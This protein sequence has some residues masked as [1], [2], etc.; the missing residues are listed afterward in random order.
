[1]SVTFANREVCDLT[2]CD[3]A[4]QRPVH[5]LDYA[6]ATTQEITGEQVFAY[7]GQGHPKRVTFYGEKGGTLAVETQLLTSELFSICTGAEI[8]NTAKFIK[9]LVLEATAGSITVPPEVNLIP[10][11][12]NVYAEAD[13]LGTPVEATLDDHTI[14][15]TGEETGNYIVYGIEELTS[16]V[17]KM[18]IKSTTFPKAVTIYGETLMKGEDG[19]NYPYKLVVYKASPQQTLSFGFSNNGD[20]ATMTI[21]F[22]L[23]SD[24]NDNIMDMILI[25]DEGA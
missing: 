3:F 7:G 4:T 19:I 17:K 25:E 13:D 2:I 5:V 24:Q 6:N 1:M 9:R 16:G 21:N 18:S 12:I 23:L 14:T 11:S 15:L 10:G 20:P 22:D 8:E